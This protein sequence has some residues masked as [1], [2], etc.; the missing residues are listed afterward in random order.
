MSGPVKGFGCRPRRRCGGLW[1]PAS[2]SLQ[3]RKPRWGNAERLYRRYG[4]LIAADAVPG[5][6]GRR[7]RALLDGVAA[8]ERIGAAE[9]GCV[10]W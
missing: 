4:D 6:V 9:R 8:S 7:S 3:G 10:D 1:R 2:E 5:V